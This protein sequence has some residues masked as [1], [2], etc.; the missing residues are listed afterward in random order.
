MSR[1][2]DHGRGQAEYV[3]E[4]DVDGNAGHWSVGEVEAPAGAHEG[5]E[6]RGLESSLV[7]ESH[8]K[9][10]RGIE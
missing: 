2:R 4:A 9:K 10:R 5:W 7:S 8:L 6:C 3:I 1:D